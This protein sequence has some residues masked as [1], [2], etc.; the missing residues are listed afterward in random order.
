[1]FLVPR[2]NEL[3]HLHESQIYLNLEGTQVWKIVEVV[4]ASTDTARF[5]I[6][7]ALDGDPFVVFISDTVLR[8]NFEVYNDV[9]KLSPCDEE[10]DILLEKMCN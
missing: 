2:R 1:M 8:C 7:I 3:I 6:G 4:P 9:N 5:M 10:L